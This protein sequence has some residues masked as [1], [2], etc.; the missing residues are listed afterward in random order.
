MRLADQIVAAGRDKRHPFQPDYQRVAMVIG[1]A[2]CLEVTPTAGRLAAD[3]GASD[4]A[5]L[6]DVHSLAVAPAQV[7]WVE[8]EGPSS[9]FYGVSD[10]VEPWQAR[11]D[12]CGLLIE[13]DAS[14]QRGTMS[15][16]WSGTAPSG[17]QSVEISPLCVTFDFRAE[18]E[19]VPSLAPPDRSS[20]LFPGG[21]PKTDSDRRIASQLSTLTR[22]EIH[23]EL[24]R[25][26]FIAN[27][28]LPRLQDTLDIA[29][30]ADPVRAMLRFQSI[31]RDWHGE[32]NFMHALMVCLNAERM[33]WIGDPEDVASKNKA[34]RRLGRPPVL[35]FSPIE[36]VAVAA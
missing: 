20:A 31:V 27:T 4:A 1:R 14:R 18:P 22:D 34:R 30:V 19:P 21:G 17:G 12:R 15:Q 35:A 13:T 2:L 29:A 33:L 26:G 7:V 9:A 36:A 24:L 28:R 25:F 11:P 5:W 10:P 32:P 16:A 6:R 23:S 3:M 8:W